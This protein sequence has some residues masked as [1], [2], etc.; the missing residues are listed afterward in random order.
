VR[1]DEEHNKGR[2]DVRC[3]FIHSPRVVKLD[4]TVHSRALSVHNEST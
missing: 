4:F 2:I 3:P 1:V